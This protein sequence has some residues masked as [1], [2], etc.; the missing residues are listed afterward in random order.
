[1]GGRFVVV[2]CF[3]MES[4]IFLTAHVRFLGS[5]SPSDVLLAACDVQFLG[6]LSP[7]S[8]AGFPLDTLDIV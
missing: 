7:P 8:L 1:M 2:G 4:D 6:S 5:S 3:A